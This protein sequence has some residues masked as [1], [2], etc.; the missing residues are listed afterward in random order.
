MVN[1]PVQVGAH[2][3][4][5]DSVLGF[6]EEEENY[7]LKEK[8]HSIENKN[9]A[10]F[11]ALN[12][13]PKYI[14]LLMEP[15]GKAHVSCGILPTKTLD[16]PADQYTQALQNMEIS[17]LTSPILTP[18]D[19]V[20]IPLPGETGYEWSWMQKQGHGWTEVNSVGYLNKEELVRAFDNAEEIWQSL[21]KRKWIE[22]WGVDMATIVP[23]DKRNRDKAEASDPVEQQKTAIEHFLDQMVIGLAPTQASFPGQV[24]VREGWLKL[25][26]SKD[27]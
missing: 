23:A 2:G 8:F 25:Y 9:P 18:A 13:A 22:V 6:W 19:T 3:Q 24:V 26:P 16:I 21:I 10:L 17:F 14:T 7:S 12:D 27:Q 4:A 20:N 1:I 11:I 15:Q 5:N